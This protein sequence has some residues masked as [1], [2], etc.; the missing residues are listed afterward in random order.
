MTVGNVFFVVASLVALF[1]AFMTIASRSPI[2]SAVGL[3]ITIVGIAALF[4][5]LNAQFL[6]AIQ[7]IV[8]AGAVVVLFGVRVSGA[9][10]SPPPRN[11]AADDESGVTSPVPVA[12]S[13]IGTWKAVTDRF[14]LTGD[15]NEKVWGRNAVSVRD[16]TLVVKPNGEAALTIAHK[17]LD[18]RGRAVPGSASVE[19]ADVVIGEAKPGLASRVDHDVRVVKA[20]R[21]YPE[22]PGDRWPL[23]NLKVNVVSFSDA[24]NTLEVRFEPADGQGSLSEQLTRQRATRGATR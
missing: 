11:P 24:P 15:F 7:L 14:P 21:R 18:A 5:M 12:V 1:G 20:E 6:A 2:R 13:L 8:Y 9:H 22:N 3:L 16:V 17:V 23:E 19:Q 4:L 10:P